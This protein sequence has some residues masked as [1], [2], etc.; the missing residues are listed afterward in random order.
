MY[1][2]ISGNS[3]HMAGSA[4]QYSTIHQ[5]EIVQSCVTQSHY[6]LFYSYKSSAADPDLD[7]VGSEP[8][9]SDPDPDPG[10]NKCPYTKLFCVWI[11]TNTF[12]FMKALFRAYFDKIKCPEKT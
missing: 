9:W 5:K 4:L 3:R 2:A 6:C 10:L 1:C 8:F 12:W 11:A 7:P